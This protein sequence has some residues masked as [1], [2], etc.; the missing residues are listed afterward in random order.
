MEY[1]RHGGSINEV[2]KL[3]ADL[4][5]FDERFFGDPLG[6]DYD[7]RFTHWSIWL[8]KQSHRS[9]AENICSASDQRLC[10]PHLW[11]VFCD[12]VGTTFVDDVAHYRT[13]SR[14]CRRPVITSFLTGTPTA[15]SYPPAACR[16]FASRRSA[17]AAP[18][19]LSAKLGTTSGS[20][21]CNTSPI[22][23]S[24]SSWI[25]GSSTAIR[26]I[27][28]QAL[29]DFDATTLEPQSCS[30]IAT[31]QPACLVLAL[32]QRNGTASDHHATDSRPCQ[33]GLFRTG[34]IN[35]GP[36]M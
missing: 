14:A 16:N 24:A 5:D 13:T 10:C 19:R 9:A 7:W 12:M 11:P 21:T 20:P 31:H 2:R 15:I 27:Y 6:Y 25:Y 32:P 26:A 35:A 28:C 29:P 34:G 1:L 3:L 18:A 33:R 8:I 4:W 36:R 23:K 30:S 22:T 17:T